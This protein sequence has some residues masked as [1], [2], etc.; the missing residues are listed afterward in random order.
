MNWAAINFD[1]N[2]VRAFLATV[3]EGSLSAAARALNQ[4]QPTL[5]RQIAALEDG[6]GVVL[7][8]RLGKRLH[9]TP[10]AHELVTH[11]RAMG[12]AATRISL[13][14][15]GQRDLIEGK[16]RITCSDIVAA[17]H[18]PRLMGGLRQAAPALEIELVVANDIRDLQAREADI[19]IRHMRPT[20]P[21]LIAR[22]LGERRAHFYGSA[23]YLDRR[24][25]PTRAA[26]LN[27]HDIVAP[28][29][30]ARMVAYL[31]PM[32]VDLDPAA[33]KLQTENGVTAWAL[34]REGLGLVPMDDSVAAMTPGVEAVLEGQLDIPF[35]IWLTTHRELHTSR[36][37]RLVFDHLYQSLK[38]SI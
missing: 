27:Q 3:E 5:S 26:E 12:E 2:Q 30:P 36:R 21:E 34:M 29:D 6:L 24:G 4:T 15:S 16:V 10:T 19:A 37:I 11:V 23:A 13:A 7:F 1:W 22:N 33:C 17:Y 31:K 28:G 25:R 20:A 32:G 35:P 8:E 9:P 14:A 38:Q 18:M